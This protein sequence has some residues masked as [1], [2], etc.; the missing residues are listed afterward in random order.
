MCP[1]WFGE[2]KSR[3]EQRWP[4]LMWTAFFVWSDSWCA[5]P[6]ER[7]RIMKIN[8][9]QPQKLPSGEEVLR[10]PQCRATWHSNNVSG[11]APC[12][13][14]KFLWASSELGDADLS[15]PDRFDRENF[16]NAYRQQHWFIYQD[17]E[18]IEGNLGSPDPFVLDQL[19]V[20]G[21]DEALFFP[22][23]PSSNSPGLFAIC[24]G[25]KCTKRKINRRKK[26]ADNRNHSR[27]NAFPDRPVKAPD[28]ASA[29][30]GRR[31]ELESAK[32][33][34]WVDQSS[35]RAHFGVPAGPGIWLFKLGLKE[36]SPHCASGRVWWRFLV[37]KLSAYGRIRTIYTRVDEVFPDGHGE[38]CTHDLLPHDISEALEILEAAAPEGAPVAMVN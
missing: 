25:I 13:C 4:S 17:D 32:S 2:T 7:R 9:I 30:L 10:C 26:H 36:D 23:I 29:F 8:S 22:E 11:F 24:I 15:C 1:E 38:F 37:V 27:I 6:Q 31:F 33:A 14:V 28:W 5:K 21:V 35:D 3:A 12:K 20:S 16:E 19:T 18:I 34:G